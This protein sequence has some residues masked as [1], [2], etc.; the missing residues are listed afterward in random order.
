MMLEKFSDLFNKNRA[1][2]W[3]YLNFGINAIFI[4]AFQ[5]LYIQKIGFENYGFFSY[6]LA[7]A[8]FLVLLGDVS[9]S[10]SAPRWIVEGR[11]NLN[12]LQK[13]RNSFL[14]VALL[15]FSTIT[16]FDSSLEPG[17]IIYLGSAI[18]L[19]PWFFQ[20]SENMAP[21]ALSN[22]IGKSFAVLLALTFNNLNFHL[23]FGIA[24]LLPTIITILWL[25]KSLSFGIDFKLLKRI[26]LLEKEIIFGRILAFF[27]TSFL[28]ILWYWLYG[29]EISGEL[30]ASFRLVQQMQ[31]LIAPF[32]LIGLIKYSKGELINLRQFFKE[33]LFILLLIIYTL[34]ASIVIIAP[35]FVSTIFFKESKVFKEVGPLLVFSPIILLVS[36]ITTNIFMLSK[37]LRKQWLLILL[38]SILLSITMQL[39]VSEY[40]LPKA[41]VGLVVLF[42][43]IFVLVMSLLCLKKN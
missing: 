38:G 10:Q 22:G 16:F 32:I 40:Q 39:L 21:L 35:D 17:L 11:F 4:L 6:L 30:S 33:P 5:K 7:M 9:F 19:S 37:G 31:A 2:V 27:Y 41:Y 1:F 14:L 8:S 18:F 23:L 3:S 15:L 28:M 34:A 26:I 29:N 43:E 25:R 20:I 12:H 24:F 42:V 36:S 13:A